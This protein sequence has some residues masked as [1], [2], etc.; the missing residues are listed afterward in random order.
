[1][2]FQNR[3]FE[4]TLNLEANWQII[5]QELEQL[6]PE[7]FTAW[8]E[9]EIYNRGWDVF[10]LYAFEKKVEEN[11][12]LCPQTT[13]LV[14][15]IPGLTTA[16]FSALKPGTHIQPHTGYTNAVLRCHL[17]L[18]V[19]DNCAIRVGDRT[20]TWQEGKCFIFDDTFEHEAWNYGETTRIVL[21]LDF[22]NPKV[23]REQIKF[24]GSVELEN[25]INQ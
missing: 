24:Q 18:I 15:Q 3:E 25:L 22:I 21:L 4:F 8:P 13:S 5:R 1:M 2:F 17:G 6:L 10:G 11:C 16:G 9:K 14:E 7:N 23:P 20:K 12:Q 19:P